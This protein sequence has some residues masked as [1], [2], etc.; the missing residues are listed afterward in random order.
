MT[1]VVI[2]T[3]AT[4]FGFSQ[5]VPIIIALKTYFVILEIYEIPVLKMHL[6][7]VYLVKDHKYRSGD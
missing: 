5:M 7:T 6:S 2:E 3:G 4:E 1:P